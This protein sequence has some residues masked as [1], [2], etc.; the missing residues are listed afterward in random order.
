M[1]KILKG[2]FN[3]ACHLTLLLRLIHYLNISMFYKAFDVAIFHV[4]FYLRELVLPEAKLNLF[5]GRYFFLIPLNM[6]PLHIVRQPVLR[7]AS[8]NTIEVA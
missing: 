5:F 1:R 4:T 7:V 8:P 6:Q 3:R 2:L